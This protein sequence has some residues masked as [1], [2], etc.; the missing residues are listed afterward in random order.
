M[1]GIAGYI[2]L[3]NSIR[4]F[5]LKEAT[6]LIEHRGPDA[7]GF[8]FTDDE[9]TGL[10]HRRLSIL[11]LSTSADQPMFSSNG[12][13]VISYNGEIYNY[14]ELKQELKDKGA[15]LKT[16]SDTEVILELFAEKG[17]SCFKNF[18]GMFALAI[19]DLEQKVLTLCRDQAGIKPLFI[20]YDETDF[21]FS[22]ELKAIK[23]IKKNQLIVNKSAIPYFL[24]LGFVPHPLTIY[25]N[26][27][28][29]PAAQLP[30]TQCK[31]K[32]FSNLSSQITYLLE[33]RVQY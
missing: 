9:K 2:S 11:D 28:K 6:K 5:D 10:G 13:Y 27:Q 4:P 18:N 31:C 19:Y 3:K 30:A 8:Y 26:V 21:I 15:S 7:E 33:P 17:I 29:F 1:C 20:Y 24:H 25:N 22:S 16:T 23:A 32:N 12:R 14:K